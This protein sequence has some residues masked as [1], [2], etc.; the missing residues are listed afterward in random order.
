MTAK[1]T[2]QTTSAEQLAANRANAGHSSGPTS[3]AGKE[4]ASANSLVHGMYASKAVAIPRGVLA[5]EP[6]QVAAFVDQCIADLDPQGA[7][8]DLVA[9]QIA[10]ALLRALRFEAYEAVLLGK[11][12]RLPATANEMI[13]EIG[14]EGE[15]HEDIGV[16][17]RFQQF[18]TTEGTCNVTT[19]DE[20][21]LLGLLPAG[22]RR[23]AHTGDVSSTPV[24]TLPER[25]TALVAAVWLGDWVAA[26]NWADA[27]SGRLRERVDQIDCGR[28]LAATGAGDRYLNVLTVIYSRLDSSL[29]RALARYAQL[30]KPPDLE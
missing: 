7:I 25:L 3:R 9:R 19:L 28:E 18:A 16:L 11:A 24:A 27:A 13:S 29:D 26:V 20:E 15:L 10:V 2:R 22:A 21:R 14:E 8:Q 1:R 5:E 6:E 4:T 23:A 30:R 17:E 12:G